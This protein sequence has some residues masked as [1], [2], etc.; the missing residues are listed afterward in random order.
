MR[1][2]NDDTRGELEFVPTLFVDRS[3]YYF[4]EIT[5]H[6]HAHEALLL[7]TKSFRGK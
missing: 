2:D 3:R 1:R 4:P 6:E 5:E 7:E